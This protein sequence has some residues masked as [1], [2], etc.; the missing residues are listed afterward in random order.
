MMEPNVELQMLKYRELYLSVKALWLSRVTLGLLGLDC[1]SPYLDILAVTNRT[2]L[3]A[4]CFVKLIIGDRFK[5][6]SIILF[7]LRMCT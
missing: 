1:A 2:H 4:S 6:C 3:C 7:K 5:S